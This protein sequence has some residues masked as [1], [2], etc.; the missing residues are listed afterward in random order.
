MAEDNTLDLQYTFILVGERPF[1]IWDS[2]LKK[3]SLEFIDTL[4][5]SYFDYMANVHL[6]NIRDG[7]EARNKES[8]YAALAMRATYSQGLETLFALISAAIQ[9]PRCVPAWMSLY[10]N[11]ELRS[12]VD[13]IHH[14]KPLLSQATVTSLSW[15]SVI[16]II[17]GHLVIEDKEKENAV[18]AGF[19]Q[20][21]SRFASDFLDDKF[22]R[23]YNSIK[24]GLRARP[25]G[26]YIAVGVQDDPKVPAPAE[27]MKLLGKSEFGTGYWATDKIGEYNNHLQLRRHYRNWDPEDIAWGLRMIAVS[28]S[29]VQSVIKIF[30]GIDASNVRFVYPTDLSWF[31]EPWKRMSNIR[32]TSMSMTDLQVEPSYIFSFSKDEIMEK[33]KDKKSIGERRLF[34][35]DSPDGGEG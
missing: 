30:N 24:H 12:V 32:V 27:N 1:C 31:Q 8:Q 17:F 20:L 35:E 2:D 29:N 14:R 25:G 7:E 9:A 10:K 6:D 3:H 19:A 21:W 33:Y 5:P 16:E 15:S 28:I 26:F 4:D 22:N 23:E 18:K 11:H 34:F 13:K